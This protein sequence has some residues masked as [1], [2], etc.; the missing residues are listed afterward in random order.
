M[1]TEL[2]T[3]IPWERFY[4]CHTGKSSSKHP[5][6]TQQETVNIK[7][8]NRRKQL[9]RDVSS[10]VGICWLNG[11]GWETYFDIPQRKKKRKKGK[12][13][14]N[15]YYKAGNVREGLIL[16]QAMDICQVL[17]TY[18]EWDLS[19]ADHRI[20][21]RKPG[22]ISSKVSFAS[23]VGG[24]AFS[25]MLWRWKPLKFY[26]SFQNRQYANDI[27]GRGVCFCK[28]LDISSF[29]KYS[30]PHGSLFTWTFWLET[31]VCTLFTQK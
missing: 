29:A 15:A 27:A 11:K 9:T 21:C 4:A 17:R 28:L 22:D 2:L 25:N 12:P 7:Q 20:H 19:R 31:L 10:F 13:L 16:T 18:M 26:T 14:R 8:N 6:K 3:Y 1:M 5:N 23:L 30:K 24:T